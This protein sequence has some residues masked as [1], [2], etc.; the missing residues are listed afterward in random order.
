MGRSRSKEFEP[1]RSKAFL[2]AVENVHGS[3]MFMLRKIKESL[4]HIDEKFKVLAK[5]RICFKYN[6]LLKENYLVHL[7]IF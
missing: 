5:I 4:Y 3:V 7:R 2:R 6:L 1:Q